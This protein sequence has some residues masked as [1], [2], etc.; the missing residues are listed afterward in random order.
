MSM[1]R[2]RD[3][4]V[5][6]QAGLDGVYWDPDPEAQYESEEEPL[7]LRPG[8]VRARALRD[9]ARIAGATN[10]RSDEEERNERSTRNEKCARA[11]HEKARKT[12]L[13]NQERSEKASQQ[14]R[15]A[16]GRFAKKK[17]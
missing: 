3:R 2:K 9:R 8:T 14:N 12:K 15:T 17:T 1:A 11:M 13:R 5:Q 7:D 4:R 16:G 10:Y 6:L